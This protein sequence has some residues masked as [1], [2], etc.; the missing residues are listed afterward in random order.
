MREPGPFRLLCW[1]LVGTEPGGNAL[2]WTSY[3]PSN[4]VW[5]ADHSRLQD[6][7]VLSKCTLRQVVGFR[8]LPGHGGVAA[9]MPPGL[10]KDRGINGVTKSGFKETTLVVSD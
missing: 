1:V 6:S 4:G 5:A 7:W 10:W 3:L 9:H 2:G 8:G